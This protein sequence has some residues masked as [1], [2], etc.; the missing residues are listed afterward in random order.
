MLE[1]IVTDQEIFGFFGEYRFLSNF[2]LS[3]VEFRGI[4]YF[5]SEGAYVA[6]TRMR[7]IDMNKTAPSQTES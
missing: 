1:S 5:H 6:E 3:T 7:S 4:T 2:F